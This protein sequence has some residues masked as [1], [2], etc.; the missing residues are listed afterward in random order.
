MKRIEQF[1][2]NRPIVFSFIITFVFILIVVV[3]TIL[4]NLW[5]GEESYGQPGSILG[6]LI[7]I[8]ILL[9][10]LSRLGWLQSAGL[11]MLGKSGIWAISVLLLLY[12]VAILNYALTGRFDLGFSSNV[13]PV[14]VTLF[15][16]TEALLENVI[17]RGLILQ[18]LVRAWG[19][20]RIGII[21][22][23]VVSALFFGSIHLLDFLGGRPL[24]AIFLQS[25]EAFFLGIVLGVLV[26]S[27]RS[28]YPAVALHGILNLSAY[29]LYGSSGSE[30]V[31]SVWLLSMLLMIPPAVFGL[32]LLN[33]SYQ[34]LSSKQPT[35]N[36]REAL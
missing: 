18:T 12:S 32:Y 4:G 35:S 21:K 3:S 6:R 16:L 33:T 8:V 26:L 23:A 7:S 11:T 24:S 17:F 30:P 25:L 36:I 1:A 15:I 27:G 34:T 9:I 10:L 28:I 31:L 5:P 2:T 22:S 14:L 29:L 19:S 13:P 20:I